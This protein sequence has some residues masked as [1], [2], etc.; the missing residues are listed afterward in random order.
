MEEGKLKLVIFDMDG[1]MFDTGRLAYRVYTKTAK[2]FDFELNPNVYYHLTGRNE[3]GFRAALKDLYGHEQP[4]DTWRDFMTKTKKEIIY[5]ERRVFKKKGLL[6]LLAYLKAND[7]LIALASGSKREIISFYLEIEE[8]PDV[9]DVIVAGDEITKGKP[10]PDIFLKACEKLNIAPSD[11]LVLEDSLAGIE[12]ASR[13]GIPSVLVEDDITD[14]EP[15]SGKYL[16]QQN[17]PINEE[18]LY[19]PTYQFD[20]LLEVKEFLKKK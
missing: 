17:L 15:V 16:L 4:T 3:A 5:S 12:A 11:A 10:H 14:L 2:E 20:D 19:K 18:R 6:E 7:Y 8:I 13:A 9:F 1:L